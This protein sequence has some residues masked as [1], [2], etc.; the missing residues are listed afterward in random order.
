M[1]KDTSPP[2]EIYINPYI[3]INEGRIHQSL[4]ENYRWKP[5]NTKKGD[6]GGYNDSVVESEN[7]Y[8]HRHREKSVKSKTNN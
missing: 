4:L 8:K 6:Q 7:C 2:T 1:R 3:P 5:Q